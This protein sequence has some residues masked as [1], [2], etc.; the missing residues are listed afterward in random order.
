MQAANI[1]DLIRKQAELQPDHVAFACV[2]SN[3]RITYGDLLQRVN[4]VA[5][6][7]QARGCRRFDRCGL[8]CP[9]GPECLINALG[10][11]AAGLAVAPISITVPPKEL[12]RA[13][14]AAGLHWLLGGD[15]KLV[16]FPFAGFVDNQEDREYRATNPA[17]IRFTSGSTGP[18]KGVLLGHN[19]ILDRLAT[20]D[21]ILRINPN[22]RVWFRLPMADH[23]VVSILLYLSRGATVLT[24]RSEEPE[25]LS[26]LVSE[27]RPTVIYGSPESYSVL[28][29][30]LSGDLATVR[31]AICT[32]T[33]LSPKTRN[34][35]QSRFGR[36]LNPALGIIE[37]GLV[38]INQTEDKPDSIG[39]AMP[40]YQVTLLDE[41]GAKVLPGK[42]GELHVNGLGLLDAYLAPWRPRGEILGTDGYATGDFATTD[43]HGYLRLVGRSKNQLEVKG[44]HFFCEE[45]EQIINSYPGVQESVVFIDPSTRALS[46]AIVSQTDSFEDLTDFLRK[47]LDPRQVPVSFRRVAEL[48]RTPNGK[49]LRH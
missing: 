39:T 2:D 3:E 28:V 45:L 34:A 30:K 36:P 5:D 12:D 24:T 26:E 1:I 37:V 22:D 44:L 42:P 48:P 17:Y 14:G 33:L 7:L 49:L 35:F 18:R 40:G 15:K 19:T 27:F 16:R 21:A 25:V 47:R 4:A 11:L 23:F 10:I 32:T 9:E 6:W 8:Y 20:A 13:I 46:A 41:N 31:L 38:T 43:E 29:E